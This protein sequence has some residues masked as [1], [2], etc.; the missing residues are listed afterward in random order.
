LIIVAIVHMNIMK[1]TLPLQYGLHGYGL[2]RAIKVCPRPTQRVVAAVA[3]IVGDLPDIPPDQYQGILKDLNSRLSVTYRRRGLRSVAG[4]FAEREDV[5][6]YLIGAVKSDPILAEKINAWNDTEWMR[7]VDLLMGIGESLSGID[8]NYF[9]IVR[10]NMRLWS[11]NFHQSR[12]RISDVF[13][14]LFR[15][16]LDSAITRKTI[17][18]DSA[19]KD[20]LPLLWVFWATTPYSDIIWKSSLQAQI[21]NTIR[22][23]R[24]LR[25]LG[26]S[27]VEEEVIQRIE[28]KVETLMYESEDVPR[29]GIATSKYIEVWEDILSVTPQQHPLK[30]L[31]KPWTG[32]LMDQELE[33]W[34]AKAIAQEDMP[35]KLIKDLPFIEVLEKARRIAIENGYIDEFIEIITTPMGLYSNRFGKLKR[36]AARKIRTPITKSKAPKQLFTPAIERHRVIWNPY[37]VD[38]DVLIHEG[39][40]EGNTKGE[41]DANGL[42]P[43]FMSGES[44]QVKVLQRS[45]VSAAD[46]P[47]FIEVLKRRSD[48]LA[49]VTPFFATLAFDRRLSKKDPVKWIIEEMVNANDESI[50]IAK[51]H[52]LFKLIMGHT[53]W[54]KEDIEMKSVQATGLMLKIGR[55]LGID[56]ITWSFRLASGVAPDKIILSR[57]TQVKKPKKSALRRRI[58]PDLVRS[59]V[60]FRPWHNAWQELGT[61]DTPDMLTAGHYYPSYYFGEKTRDLSGLYFGYRDGHPDALRHTEDILAPL[62]KRWADDPS[63]K[64]EVVLAP[65]IGT[66]PNKKLAEQFGYPIT[67][68]WLPRPDNYGEGVE[69]K[70]AYQKMEMVSNALRLD[71]SETSAIKGR[72]VLIVDDNITDA[73]TYMVARRLLY[74]AGAAEVGIVALTETIRRPEDHDWVL[75]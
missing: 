22:T 72:S 42:I 41:P 50:Y 24:A 18:D 29:L 69:G 38:D 31:A 55:M 62:V 25:R 1:H 71:P 46:R 3:K 6:E 35:E 16:P 27:N 58:T 67:F 47:A 52:D 26:S 45:L 2:L 64:G 68:P 37:T 14:D 8:Q 65:M 66:A 9:N 11:H 20:A 61:V 70:T 48:K 5:R 74:D 7:T 43:F 23:L 30:P 33:S 13:M 40:G 44:M 17:L 21:R 15:A 10:S 49:Y 53:H 4:I 51:R 54:S 39:Y 32:R 75:R 60:W 73:A 28:D 12:D 34:I 63:R 56:P 19:W 59:F 36:M 57:K